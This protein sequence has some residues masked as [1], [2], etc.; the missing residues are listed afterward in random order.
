MLPATL[1][2]RTEKEESNMI[3]AIFFD[4]DGTLISFRTH[5]VPEKTAEALQA[6]R[7]KGIKLFI[8]TGRSAQSIPTI[9]RLLNFDFDGYISFNG[10]HCVLGEKV[11]RQASL[12]KESLKAIL[13]YLE[14]QNIACVF[15]EEEYQYLNHINQKVL[16]IEALLGSTVKAVP[17]DA[18]TRVYDHETY[19]LCAY[20][21]EEEEAEF[22]AHMPGVKGV[23]W[24]PLFTDIIPADGG[25]PAG[26]ELILNHFGYT[27]EECMA[28]G[29]GGNDMEMLRFAGIGVAMGNAGEQVKQAADYVTDD[30]DSGG[31]YNALVHFGVL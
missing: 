19:Q 13:P 5:T 21:S 26:I 6:L 7:K 8:A 18:V 29:D 2:F 15:M 1:L 17:E 9:K 24:N 25:K 11:L 16:D 27:R 30:V 14:G 10:Q 3:K 4:I 31:I 23:R 12:P 22:L 20:I 28:F